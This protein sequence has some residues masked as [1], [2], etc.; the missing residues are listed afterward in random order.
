MHT[1]DKKDLSAL[2]ARLSKKIVDSYDRL[3]A[4]LRRTLQPRVDELKRKASTPK[5]QQ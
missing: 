4:A 5:G 1:A 2:E 3:K